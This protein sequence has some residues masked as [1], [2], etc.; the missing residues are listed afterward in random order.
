MAHPEGVQDECALLHPSRVRTDLMTFPGVSCYRT[1]PL[2]TFFNPFGVLKL[3]LNLTLMPLWGFRNLFSHILKSKI[4]IYVA[5]IPRYW[6]FY[7]YL[8]LWAYHPRL[9]C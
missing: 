2:A 9:W 5:S 8:A 4:L 6:S 7:L 1:Q 3:P